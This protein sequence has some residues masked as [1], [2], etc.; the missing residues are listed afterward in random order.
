MGWLLLSGVGAFFG[1]LYLGLRD[2]LPYLG[3]KRSGVIT[4]KGARAVRVRRDEDPERFDQLLANRAKGTAVGFGLAMA[5]ALVVS[6]FG[7]GLFGAAGPL[8]T[9]SVIIFVGIA[10]FA[11]VCLIRGFATG[12]MFAFWSMALYGQA[13]LKQNP[14]W[15]WVYAVMNLLILS[16][17]LITVLTALR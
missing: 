10:V 14:T 15:F 11:G 16:L 7:L 2:L 1:G 9:V 5:G 8:A 4:R 6:L 17:S 12:R 13:A 3:A